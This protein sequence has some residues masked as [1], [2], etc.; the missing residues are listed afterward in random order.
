M[1]P[2]FLNLF[3]TSNLTSILLKKTPITTTIKKRPTTTCK[4]FAVCC[5]ISK[6]TLQLKSYL[7][8]NVN[9]GLSM[10][11]LRVVCFKN[12]W[13]CWFYF[14]ELFFLFS[15]TI[16]QKFFRKLAIKQKCN[17]SILS[18]NGTF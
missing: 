11:D 15:V 9:V 4:K 8:E 12:I 5:E 17:Y 3:A 2:T 1:F 16:F 14:F 10:E 6:F 18:S 7:L 13:R